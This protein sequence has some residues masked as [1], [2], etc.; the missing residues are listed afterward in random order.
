MNDELYF[1]F[2]RSCLASDVSRTLDTM[3]CIS[4]KPNRSGK[5]MSDLNDDDPFQNCGTVDSY[6]EVI[7]NSVISG[8]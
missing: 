3:G 5:S 2:N 8:E 7:H 4:A 6:V 1:N